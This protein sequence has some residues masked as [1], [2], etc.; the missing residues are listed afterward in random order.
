VVFA[1]LVLPNDEE[2]VRRAFGTAD[3]LLLGL[4]LGIRF[5]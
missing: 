4:L 5:H 1:R 3:I 2:G